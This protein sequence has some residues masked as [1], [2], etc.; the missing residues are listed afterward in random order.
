MKGNWHKTA[1]MKCWG[2]GVVFIPKPLLATVTCPECAGKGY[3]IWV[4]G[5]PALDIESVELP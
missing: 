1:C 2:V 4:E 3:R 5:E